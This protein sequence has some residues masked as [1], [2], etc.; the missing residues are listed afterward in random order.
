MRLQSSGGGGGGG[1]GINGGGSGGGCSVDMIAS[2]GLATIDMKE[3]AYKR[4][5]K[6]I[7]AKHK[8]KG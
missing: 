8:L 5:K 3:R 6:I 1:G 4:K 7:H 2:T